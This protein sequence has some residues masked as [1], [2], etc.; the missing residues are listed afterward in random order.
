MSTATD[1]LRLNITLYVSV[2]MQNYESLTQ[3]LNNNFDNWPLATAHN[4]DK[5]DFKEEEKE[6]T[7]KTNYLII[8]EIILLYR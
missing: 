5:E 4:R 3:Q 2:L 8:N 7:T 6:Q 1:R